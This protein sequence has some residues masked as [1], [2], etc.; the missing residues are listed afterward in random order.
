MDRERIEKLSKLYS[1]TC[2]QKYWSLRNAI[3]FSRIFL[4]SAFWAAVSA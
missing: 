1:A 4:K 3:R 2:H